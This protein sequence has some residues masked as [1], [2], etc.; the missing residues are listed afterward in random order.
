MEKDKWGIPYR[1]KKEKDAD[2]F[3]FSDF[4]LVDC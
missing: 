1:Y 3:S 4:I 2:E